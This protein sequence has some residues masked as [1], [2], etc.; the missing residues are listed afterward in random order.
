MA[1]VQRRIVCFREDGLIDVIYGRQDI[2]LDLG[3][4]LDDVFVSC[5]SDEFPVCYGS[6][7]W[8]SVTV[9]DK[10]F[11]IHADVQTSTAQVRWT[12]IGSRGNRIT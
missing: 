11:I 3:Y 2:E 1:S 8:L 9:L 7:N 10:G 5:T 12:A 4:D 6:L